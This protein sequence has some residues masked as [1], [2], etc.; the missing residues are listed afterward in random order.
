MSIAV[1]Q[2]LTTGKKGDGEPLMAA[3]RVKSHTAPLPAPRSFSA[4]Q[5]SSTG[6]RRVKY[7]DS[8]CAKRLSLGYHFCVVSAAMASASKLA[9][10]AVASSKDCTN[11]LASE[12]RRMSRGERSWVKWRQPLESRV[13]LG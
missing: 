3:I 7:Y 10:P 6:A 8:V 2:I 11:A 1:R 12:T 5:H 13:R 4:V 9:L